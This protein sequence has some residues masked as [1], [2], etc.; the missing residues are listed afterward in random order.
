MSE[1]E[2]KKKPK[3]YDDAETRKPGL[4]I[5]T[6]YKHGDSRSKQFRGK[7]DIVVT[8]ADPNEEIVKTDD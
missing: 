3:K 5:E 8:E 4:P 2:P 1:K 6:P 7:R